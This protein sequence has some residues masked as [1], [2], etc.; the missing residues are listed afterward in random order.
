MLIIK[1]EQMKT[2][3]YSVRERFGREVIK[4][5]E[6]NVPYTMKGL[7]PA[8]VDARLATAL[9]K[10]EE[11]QLRAARDLRA[12]IRLCFVV[13]PLFADYPYVQGFLGKTEFPGSKRMKA[14]FKGMPTHGWQYAADYDIVARA[15]DPVPAGKH[16]AG[17]SLAWDA[18]PPA[19]HSVSIEPLG[20]SHANHY[21]RYAL[22][23]D[24]WRLGRMPPRT[25]LQETMA[26]IRWTSACDGRQAYAIT[27]A[28]VGF[29]GAIILRGGPSLATVT[30]WVAR[31][32]WGHGTATEAIRK[33]RI[34]LR[35]HSQIRRLRANVA[36]M[37]VPSVQVVERTGWEELA[38][39]HDV[40]GDR[41][42]E[43][44]V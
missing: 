22:H 28:S 36:R 13:G 7:S 9:G 14:L 21:F 4:G 16:L 23:P 1:N 40:S 11:F 43:V 26:Y 33:L 42:Y 27:D 25:S 15:R 30:Y 12:F 31:P 38:P 18:P 44:D 37:N 20:I 3:D 32:Y 10:A 29:V 6:E 5:I 8:E 35:E 34:H 41:V 2:L 17:D 39:A 24:V 19:S